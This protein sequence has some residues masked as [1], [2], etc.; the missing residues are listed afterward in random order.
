M[1]NSVLTSTFLLTVLLTVGLFFFI[2]ASVKDRTQVVQLLSESSEESLLEQLRQYFLQR[3]YRVAQVDAEAN[4]VTF[5]GQVRPS[6]FL[7]VFLA[8][9]AALGGLCLVLVLSMVWPTFSAFWFSL[10]IF[11]PVTGVFY[12]R[13]AGRSEQVV[14]KVESE[15]AAVAGQTLVTVTAHRDEL[16][17]L[18]K[19]LKLKLL[20]E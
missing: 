3:A 12:W 17:E 4:S 9:L 8:L 18:Q 10:L 15:K 13:K 20:A 2:R 16:A 19:A 7:A 1:S 5:E 6:L 14:L 11:A